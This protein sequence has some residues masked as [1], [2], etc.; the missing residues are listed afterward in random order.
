MH[1]LLFI[2]AVMATA[3][4]AHS[5]WEHHR[6]DLV[7]YR[8]LG[9]KLAISDIHC[10]MV[11]ENAD[12][13]RFDAASGSCSL[14]ACDRGAMDA[15]RKCRHAS[16]S[17]LPQLWMRKPV[18]CWTTFQHRVDGSVSFNRNWADY[19]SG[20]GQ[21]ESLNYWMGL[22]Q[23]HQLT[24]T[25][26]WRVRWEFSDWNGT[27]YWAENAPFSVGPASDKFRCSMG[28]LDASRSSVGQRTEAHFST[29]NW[30]FST[31]DSDNDDWSEGSCAP[32]S[33]WWYG[34]CSFMNP[35][36]VYKEYPNINTQGI[37]YYLHESGS[38]LV[39]SYSMK[40]FECL[41]FN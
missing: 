32:I 22:E 39:M 9:V 35:N 21:G 8:V 31:P 38:A 19:A 2:C 16:D 28:P 30:Q 40:T 4:A 6:G 5:G 34:Q 33:G 24:A 1:S 25:G 37:Y 41:I 17:S 29:N 27:W 7:E 3:T 14:L 15:C 18:K 13:V 11:A 23:L 36:A 12:A 10:T 26:V 20:F